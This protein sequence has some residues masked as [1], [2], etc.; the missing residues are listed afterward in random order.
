MKKIEA[1]QT[2][3][4]KVFTSEEDAREAEE[5]AEIELL[6]KGWAEIHD[7]PINKEHVLSFIFDNKEKFLKNTPRMFVVIEGGIVSGIFSDTSVEC[8]V[9]DYDYD[10]ADKKCT[11]SDGNKYHGYEET[12]YVEKDLVDETFKEVN[13]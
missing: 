7:E 3:D 2:E 12:C 1:F 5:R 11:D 6:Y 4:G 13:G 9:K 8:I 10:D